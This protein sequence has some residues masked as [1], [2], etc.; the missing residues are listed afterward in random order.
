MTQELNTGNPLQQKKVW[1]KP[2]FYI[3]DTDDI[4]VKHKPGIHEGTGHKT[5]FGSFLNQQN[6]YAVPYASKSQLIS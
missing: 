3:L 2:E 1:E 5:P 6:N 4:H